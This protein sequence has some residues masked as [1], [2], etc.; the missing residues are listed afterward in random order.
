[1][2]AE[3]LRRLLPPAWHGAGRVGVACSGGPDSMALLLAAQAAGAAPVALHV[4]HGLRPESAA[5]AAWLEAQCAR[6]GIPCRVRRVHVPDSGNLEAAA[7]AARRAALAELARAQGLGRVWLAHHA[8]DQAETVFLRMG[9]GAG[10]RGAAGMRARRV[11]EGIVWERPLLGVRRAAILEALARAGVP[12]L[13]DPMNDDLRFRRNRVR[14]LVFPAAARCGT[15]PVALF[16]RWGRAAAGLAA[17]IEAAAGLEAVR[18]HPEGACVPWR[19]WRCG[20]MALRAARLQRMVALALGEGCAPGR[21]HIE[22]AERWTRR[23][24]RGGLDLSRARLERRGAWLVLARR[25]S[26]RIHERDAT[27]PRQQACNEVDS[28]AT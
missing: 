20:G 13:A 2:A 1:M 3:V 6:R 28:C 25:A 7:R 15:D 22:L 11:Q 5:E 21:R 23:G 17:R 24:G 8:D 27:I 10:P 19:A 12:F 26:S 4:D 16:L 14:H 18:A 9:M